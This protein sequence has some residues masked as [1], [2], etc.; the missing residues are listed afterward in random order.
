VRRLVQRRRQGK[1]CIT[2]AIPITTLKGRRRFT[3][4]VVISRQSGAGSIDNTQ[5]KRLETRNENEEVGY[6][7]D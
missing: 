4:I 3:K 6:E 7:V 1:P 5:S 2:R